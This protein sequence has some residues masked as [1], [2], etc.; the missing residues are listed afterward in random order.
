MLKELDALCVTLATIPEGS[1]RCQ[2]IEGKELTEVLAQKSGVNL[3]WLMEQTSMLAL[4]S[5]W[6]QASHAWRYVT[7]EPESPPILVFDNALPFSV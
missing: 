3:R 6:L 4:F 1:E 2:P 7:D 5:F